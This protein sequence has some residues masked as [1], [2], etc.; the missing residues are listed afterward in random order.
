MKIV[1]VYKESISEKDLNRVS[2]KRFFK[3]KKEN[4]HC[5]FWKAL[6]QKE[7]SPD[8]KA[9]DF[10]RPILPCEK[11]YI[12]L[13]FRRGTLK[14]NEPISQKCGSMSWTSIA[15]I[16]AIKKSKQG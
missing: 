9:N 3:E 7:L 5:G 2:I 11:P 6:M 8:V 15:N 1:L 16:W 10:K 14:L 12:G 4:V 13:T